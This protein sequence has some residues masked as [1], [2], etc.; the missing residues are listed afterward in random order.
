MTKIECPKCGESI[1]SDNS[2]PEDNLD[3]WLDAQGVFNWDCHECG[4]EWR[5]DHLGK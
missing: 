4:Y 1:E 5:G 2:K 3:W